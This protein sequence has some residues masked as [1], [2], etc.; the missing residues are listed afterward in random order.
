MKISERKLKKAE[1][2]I[3]RIVND[4]FKPQRG[5]NSLTPKIGIGFF[6][7]N[8]GADILYHKIDVE[9]IWQSGDYKWKRIAQGKLEITVFEPKP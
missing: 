6:S 1:Q 4:L 7:T 2:D 9:R 5:L 8:D 3:T